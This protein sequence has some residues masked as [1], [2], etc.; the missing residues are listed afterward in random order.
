[1]VVLVRLGLVDFVRNQENFPISIRLLIYPPH[2]NAIMCDAFV[3]M[4]TIHIW[5]L[6]GLLC[7]RRLIYACKVY[8]Y[9]SS[10][11]ISRKIQCSNFKRISNVDF[12]RIHKKST[13]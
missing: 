6:S 13:E 5:M 3:V 4:Y 10:R 2:H 8:R 11:E 1:M 9:Y 12:D 7:L